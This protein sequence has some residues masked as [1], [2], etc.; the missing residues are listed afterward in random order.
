MF[1][2]FI[3]IGLVL[4]VLKLCG[5]VSYPWY[6]S[7]TFAITYFFLVPLVDLLILTMAIGMEYITN[8]LK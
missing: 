2:I 1:G 3:I 5:L 6:A 7:D 4:T 8:S